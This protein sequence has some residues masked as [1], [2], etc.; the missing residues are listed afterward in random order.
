M[1][2]RG[3]K[4]IYRCAGCNG[5][6][7]TVDRD[8]GVTPFAIGC[9]ATTGCGGMMESSFYRVDQD[10]TPEYEWYYMTEAEAATVSRA[11]RDHHDHGGL[12]LRKIGGEARS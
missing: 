12:A 4:N 8:E 1:S 7:V 9:R 5:T 11:M 2:L 6:I 3:K 10:A